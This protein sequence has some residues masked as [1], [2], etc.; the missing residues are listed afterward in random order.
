MPRS[1]GIQSPSTRSFLDDL[2]DRLRAD[3]PRR[4]GERTR[5]RMR[6]AAGRALESLGFRGL[7]IIDVTSR[8][9][10]SSGAFYA[11]FN[12][13]NEAALAVLAPLAEVIYGALPAPGETLA[14]VI[15][16]WLLACRANRGLMRCFSHAA[17]EI[18]AFA[19]LVESRK[20]MWVDAVT[21]HHVDRRETE[22]PSASGRPGETAALASLV[23]GL[24]LWAAD[25]VDDE[26]GLLALAAVAADLWA[27]CLALRRRP[28]V[29]AA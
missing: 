5:E 7:R 18:P 28:M 12:D 21:Q 11:Y 14:Q 27:G 9:R 8:A 22:D 13:R 6:I 24:A 10:T 20:A 1:T 19:A 17:E 16:R 2:E 4:K 25:E 26:A 23:N 3:P 29:A 15:G